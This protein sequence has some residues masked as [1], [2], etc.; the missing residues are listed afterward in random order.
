LSL[1]DMSFRRFIFPAEGAKRSVV[2]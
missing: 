2:K 1:K